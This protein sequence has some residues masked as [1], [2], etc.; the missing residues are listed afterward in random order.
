MSRIKRVVCHA[1]R[2]AFPLG[3]QQQTQRVLCTVFA[4][5]M[6]AAEAAAQAAA[7]N[8]V[9]A[10]LRHFGAEKRPAGHFGQ[11]L[12]FRWEAAVH[13]ALGLRGRAARREAAPP[14]PPQAG[15]GSAGS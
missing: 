8:A 9:A 2:A 3:C 7:A 1:F 15:S 4:E 10:T 13:T 5:K 6:L 14:P 12:S 11:V